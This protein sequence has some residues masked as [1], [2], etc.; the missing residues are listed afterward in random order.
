MSDAH[1][2]GHIPSTSCLRMW[3]SHH[4]CHFTALRNCIHTSSV[5]ICIS[6]LEKTC[7]KAKAYQ[8]CRV[9]RIHLVDPSGSCVIA[10]AD[11]DDESDNKHA[12]LEG[13]T[14]QSL[15]HL[16]WEDGC[17]SLT[18]RLCFHSHSASTLRIWLG[19]MCHG[20]KSESGRLSP[21]LAQVHRS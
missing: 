9:T 3:N 8:E 21:Q 5:K 11:S 13:V 18:E 16:G 10:A 6:L 4:Q 7:I 19:S 12:F 14:E 1:K 20:T 17:M 2:P 15:Q